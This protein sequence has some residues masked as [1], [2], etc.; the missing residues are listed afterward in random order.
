MSMKKHLLLICLMGVF[1]LHTRAQHSDSLYFTQIKIAPLKMFLNANPG[2]EFSIERLIRPR[3]SLQV[4]Y[5][6]L[7]DLFHQT[8]SESF[9][10]YQAGLE[11]KLFQKVTRKKLNY[12]S[13][14][15]RYLKVE[16]EKALLFTPAAAPEYTDTATIS[17]KTIALNF[18]LGRMYTMGHFVIDI[19]VGAGLKYKNITHSGRIHP[20]DPLDNPVDPNVYY[21]SE[22]PGKGFVLNLPVIVRIGYS[23]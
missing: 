14:E 6:F 17:R 7:T 9:K 15:V 8:Y 23:F 16:Q 12:I 2:I 18:K 20:A 10:G 19:G 3:Y 11:G 21:P 22:N 13:T 1:T 4:S 5:A